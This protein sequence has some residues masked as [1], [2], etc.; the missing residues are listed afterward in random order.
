[1]SD[2]NEMIKSLMGNMSEMMGQGTGSVKKEWWQTYNFPE[3]P[4]FCVKS[5][6]NCARSA[7]FGA[8]LNGGPAVRETTWQ[9]SICEKKNSDVVS[10]INGYIT[11]E[12]GGRLVYVFDSRHDNTGEFFYVFSGGAILA[13][14][15]NALCEIRVVGT[16]QAHMQ[17]GKDLLDTCIKGKDVKVETE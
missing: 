1:M 4:N 5:L 16:A 9:E 17:L 7:L 10:R 12:L 14:I 15:S 2:P 8:A 11:N 13:H 3:T 6:I